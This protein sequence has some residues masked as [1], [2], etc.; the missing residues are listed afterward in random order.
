MKL[1]V[2]GGLGFIGSS[3]VR[4]LQDRNIEIHILN[5]LVSKTSHKN[6]LVWKPLLQDRLHIMD[7]EDEQNVTRLI[8]KNQF[9]VIIHL[10][11]KAGVR[12]SSVYPQSYAQSNVMGTLNVLHA[13]RTHSPHTRCILASS[14]TVHA[15]PIC[16]YYGLTKKMM[17]EMAE[18]FCRLYN[19]NIACLR[20]FS[21]YGSDCRRDLLIGNIITCIREK[22]PLRIFGDGQIRRDF[23]YIDDTLEAIYRTSQKEWTGYFVADVGTGENHS[24]REVVD[25]FNTSQYLCAPLHVVYTEGRQEDATISKACTERAFIELDFESKTSLVEGLQKILKT[26]DQTTTPKQTID[27]MIP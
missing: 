18:L 11:A 9:D 26:I 6:F 20:F 21:V 27:Q 16:S 25:L 1:L 19:M 13:V 23:T 5:H 2:T 7:I 10:A 17:E 22:K 4:Y 12:E 8:K 15:S 24:I 14:S 3:L